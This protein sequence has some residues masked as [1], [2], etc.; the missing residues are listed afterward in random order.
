MRDETW[1][2]WGG[3]ST[4]FY[5]A[6]SKSK[7]IFNQSFV[8]FFFV[9]CFRNAKSEML[10]MSAIS[11]VYLFDFLRPHFKFLARW[12]TTS[13]QTDFWPASV[14]L[15][16][17]YSCTPWKYYPLPLQRTN[18]CNLALDGSVDSTI[19]PLRSHWTLEFT[20]SPIFTLTGG[21]GG[22]STCSMPFEGFLSSLDLFPKFLTNLKICLSAFLSVCPL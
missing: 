6:K 7:H 20:H 9:W 15:S 11:L 8:S 18:V 13:G 14:F 12:V 16:K 19:P 22:V 1:K 10:S 17:T 3:I 4:S 2:R 21:G 5:L